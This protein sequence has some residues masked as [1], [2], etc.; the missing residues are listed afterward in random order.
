MKKAVNPRFRG[1][2][3]SEMWIRSVGW[4]SLQGLL[5]NARLLFPDEGALARGTRRPDF[6]PRKTGNSGS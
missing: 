1:T 2:F 4:M 3:R 5:A 6:H